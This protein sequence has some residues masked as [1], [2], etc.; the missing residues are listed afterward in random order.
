MKLIFYHLFITRIRKRCIFQSILA[1]N[2]IIFQHI[3][4]HIHVLYNMMNN[5]N[6]NEIIV[7]YF[8]GVHQEPIRTHQESPQN[9]T[10]LC[11]SCWWFL[12]GSYRVQ[13][14]S[15]FIKRSKCWTNSCIYSFLTLIWHIQVPVRNTSLDTTWVF[16]LRLFGRFIEVKSNPRRK[17]LQSVSRLPFS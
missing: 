17:K 8:S 9:H 7:I 15:C 2:V 10:I 3:I 4:T 5:V 13:G 12:I 6:I 16:H 14:G 1:T 11:N